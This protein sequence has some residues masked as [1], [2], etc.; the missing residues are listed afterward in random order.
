MSAYRTAGYEALIE[1]YRLD[2][3]PNWHRSFVAVETQVHK[4]EKDHNT[5]RE[6]YPERYWPGE[7]VG[8]QLEFA[9]KYDG[10]NLAILFSVFKTMDE[11][12]SLT[13]C[14]PNLQGNIHVVYGTCMNL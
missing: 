4:I 5:V 6:H 2:V 8:E 7:S 13:T 3:I 11:K 10:I 14:T 9:L 1:R 12:N